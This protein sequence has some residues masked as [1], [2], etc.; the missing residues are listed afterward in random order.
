MKDKS[1]TIRF[2]RSGPIDHV[3][4]LEATTNKKKEQIDFCLARLN[5]DEL[6][7]LMTFFIRLAASHRVGS[8]TPLVSAT[9]QLCVSSWC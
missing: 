7:A 2:V 4:L 3:L 6:L 8:A 9:N 5:T 1:H